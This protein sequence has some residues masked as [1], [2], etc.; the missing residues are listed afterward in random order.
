ME[1]RRARR[2]G[3]RDHGRGGG[4]DGRGLPRRSHRHRGR[5]PG[6][7]GA[8]RGPAPGVRRSRWTTRR[9]TRRER[10]GL[11]IAR[12]TGMFSVVFNG[13]VNQLTSVRAVSAEYP[14]RG[15]VMLSDEPFGRAGCSRTAIRHAARCGR[16]RGSRRRWAPASARSSTSARARSASSRILISRPDQGATFLDLA[17]SLLM[18]EADLDATQ[19]IQPGSRA[20]A[21]AA[22]RGTARGDRSVQGMARSEQ[23]ANEEIEDVEE[24]APQIKSAI[25]R[26]ARFLSHREPGR[27]AA[28]RDRG[29]DGGAPLRA[30]ASRLRRAA[31]DARRD[32]R[33]S[34]LSVSLMQLVIVGLL[35]GDPWLVAGL[36]RAGVAGECAHGSAR[37]GICRRR[38]WRRSASASSPRSRCSADSRCRR[39]CSCRARRRC[40]SCVA[41]WGRR[42]RW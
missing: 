35:A 3:A 41:T 37:A 9:S 18:N 2:A 28:V 23:E 36:R 31:E 6:G 39:C 34:R 27:G 30:A 13:D 26:S 10:R 8:R 38:A 7:R 24:T 14:L 12:S 5:Q 42:R 15:R 1:V 21:R 20:H 22:V 25:D 4:A 32:A 19:L 16:I 33:A 29:G 40:A 17:P 11:E